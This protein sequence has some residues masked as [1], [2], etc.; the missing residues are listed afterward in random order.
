MAR[1]AC[2]AGARAQNACSTDAL[3]AFNT[4]V[5]TV[6][7]RS[8]RAAAVQLAPTKTENSS[9]RGRVQQ[10][11]ALPDRR[12]LQT[13]RHGHAGDQCSRAH[14]GSTDG[15]CRRTAARSARASSAAAQQALLDDGHA[16]EQAVLGLAEVSAARVAVHLDVNL[17]AGRA[18]GMRWPRQSSRQGTAATQATQQA[19]QQAVGL[20]AG[21]SGSGCCARAR[22]CA[23][24]VVAASDLLHCGRLTSSTRGSGCSTT[25]SLCSCFMMSALMMY[26]PARQ[27]RGRQ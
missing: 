13:R 23:A 1:G 20:E 5:M 19:A 10:R 22:A 17:A 16:D 9:H 21:K 2:L 18:G 12:Q 8:P 11:A 24:R 25:A 6:T 4:Q 14:A 26:L 7:W 3:V 27:E 15:R